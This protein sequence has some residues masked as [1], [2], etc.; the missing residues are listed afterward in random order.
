MHVC[1][2]HTPP[3]SASNWLPARPS[4]PPSPLALAINSLSLAAPHPSTVLL[5]MW[6]AKTDAPFAVLHP[7]V[8]YWGCGWKSWRDWLGPWPSQLLPFHEVMAHSRSAE[9]SSPRPTFL[10]STWEARL[11]RTA[12]ESAVMFEKEDGT[13]HL[14]K[15]DTA[16]VVTCER[17]ALLVV[18]MA[19]CSV[20]LPLGMQVAMWHR[21]GDAWPRKR[22]PSSRLSL[23]R[24]AEAVW[25][26]GALGSQ[27]GLLTIRLLW[28]RRRGSG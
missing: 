8:L 16:Y 25:S 12:R 15:S 21:K 28:L 2:A 17:E 19:V 20:P 4:L 13:S 23:P 11:N 1:V 27:V 5:Q 7:E 14:G 6:A 24:E 9:I 26:S 3:P 10:P 22:T 18:P